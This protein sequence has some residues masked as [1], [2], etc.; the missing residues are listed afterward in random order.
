M[1]T[2]STQMAPVRFETG[3]NVPAQ[4]HLSYIYTIKE[5]QARLYTLNY[6]WSTV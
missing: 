6:K 5:E 2:T 3:E 1:S 4:G